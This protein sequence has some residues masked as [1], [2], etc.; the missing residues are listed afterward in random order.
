[1]SR[2]KGPIDC[3]P[4]PLMKAI[5]E[6]KMNET[7]TMVMKTISNQQSNDDDDGG[8]KS[9]AKVA[10]CPQKSEPK[11]F[12]LWKDAL[13]VACQYTTLHY[14]YWFDSSD[15]LCNAFL[16]LLLSSSFYYPVKTKKTKRKMTMT[17][18]TTKKV[19]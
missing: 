12:V 3:L 5:N 15:L 19:L 4:L 14:Y 1:M 2:M 8:G 7:M 16:D 10:F 17:M 11:S 6:N 9:E 13:A 18:I